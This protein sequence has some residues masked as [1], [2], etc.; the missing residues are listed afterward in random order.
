MISKT[1]LLILLII[2]LVF[3][4]NF[5]VLAIVNNFNTFEFNW[6]ETRESE[7]FVCNED[8]GTT[9][10][11]KGD[12][13]Y[14]EE[15]SDCVRVKGDCCGCSAGGEDIV[16]NKN[17]RGGWDKHLLESCENIACLQIFACDIQPTI[18]KCI[19]NRCVLV[20]ELVET[21][22]Q[23]C[24]R[25]G[26]TWAYFGNTCGD[27]CQKSRSDPPLVCGLTFTY[28]CNCGEDMCWN[29]ENCELN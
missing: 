23:K 17:S 27:S 6:Q 11:V 24:E 15:D 1:I 8:L 16:I 22:Q 26:G 25:V 10:C 20:E 29:G 19:H 7:G 13:F 3:G 18:P 4:V 21:F 2:L 9:I 5:F 12:K 28:S 14:C